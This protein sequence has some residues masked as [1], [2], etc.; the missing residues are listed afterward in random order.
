M[1]SINILYYTLCQYQ[2]TNEVHTCHGYSRDSPEFWYL[3][4]AEDD[5]DDDFLQYGVGGLGVESQRVP[6]T[7]LIQQ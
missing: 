2:R 4:Q 6:Q 7:A 5:F 3:T 1:Q